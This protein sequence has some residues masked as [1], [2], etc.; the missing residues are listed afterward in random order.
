MGRIGNGDVGTKHLHRIDAAIMSVRIEDGGD[1]DDAVA[2][3]LLDHGAP[4]CSQMVEHWQRGIH[5]RR[6]SAMHPVIQPQDCRPLAG[7]RGRV[8]LGEMGRTDILYAGLVFRCR[9]HK[10]QDR[11]VFMGIADSLD[12]DAIG[13]LR[14]LGEI[15]DQLVRAHRALANAKAQPVFG[16]RDSRV[17]TGVLQ[18]VEADR[19]GQCRR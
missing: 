12:R 18:L 16:G 10:K 6:F 7:R 13:D 1:Q 3:R 9:D 5:A 8:K 15:A 11:A 14:Q 17:I 4:G 19:F 2:Q